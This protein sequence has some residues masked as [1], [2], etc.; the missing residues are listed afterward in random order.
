MRYSLFIMNGVFRCFLSWQDS[1]VSLSI[2]LRL[3]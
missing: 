1:E 2:T 3:S